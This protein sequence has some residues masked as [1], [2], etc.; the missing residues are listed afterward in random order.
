[1]EADTLIVKGTNN[2]SI[3][4]DMILVT[5]GTIPN[6]ALAHSAGIEIGAKR[7]IKVNRR[8][9]TRTP[10]VYAAGDKA[11]GSMLCRV[12]QFHGL[13]FKLGETP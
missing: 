2:F 12:G 13:L 7:A 1:M 8:M 5:V 6:P 9:E 4:T 10:D 3:S 11:S